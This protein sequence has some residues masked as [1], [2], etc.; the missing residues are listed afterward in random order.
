MEL[1]RNSNIIDRK[2]KEFFIPSILTAMSTSMILIVDGLIVSNMLGTKE[3]AAVNCCLPF[4]Q[5]L[6]MISDLLGLGGSV[7]I[8]IARG[9]RENRKADQLF[10]T[11]LL[12]YLVSCGLLW[13]PQ[14]LAPAFFSRI[15]TN[16]PVL[17]PYVLDYYSVL[18]WCAPFAIFFQAMAYIIRAEGRP[19][20]ASFITITANVINVVLDVVFMGIFRMGIRGAALASV[21]GWGVGGIISLCS[22]LFGTRPLKICFGR[23]GSCAWEIIKTGFPGAAGV[24]LVG[25]KTL[26]LNKIVTA[27]AGSEGM[28]AFSVC[29]SAL[30]LVSMFITGASETMMPILGIYYGENDSLGV[31]M[32]LR[33]A[34]RILVVSSGALLLV[35]EAAPGLLLI[36]YGVTD[37]AEV[38]VAT[39]ALRIYALSLVG[40]AISY[41]M[42]YYYL[43][44]E[45]QKLANLIML[46][47][48]FLVIVPCA[49]VLSKLMGI[50]G[51]WWSFG[52]TEL[53]TIAFI[54]V[55]AR[56]K[57]SNIYQMEEDPAMLE[58]SFLGSE[59]PGAEASMKVMQFLE[60]QGMEHKLVNKI[61]IA[62]EE[63]AEN[64]ARHSQ[65]KGN[66]IDLRLKAAS[67]GVMI[68]FCDDGPEFDPTVYQPE[69]KD[70]YAIDN[71]MML[72]AISPKMEYQRVIGLNKTTIF[73]S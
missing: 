11:L 27:T 8:S 10:T 71:I 18:V 57:V 52:I 68:S 9:R 34:F 72:R 56:G 38:A 70:C 58:V 64:I 36:P 49:Y 45:K 12:L 60:N 39:S 50:N 65:G 22:V 3:F 43:T 48:G 17:Y 73:L 63:M 29:I 14:V 33:K 28:V 5:L 55:M 2:F 44:I 15:L 46:I 66:H 37:P 61:G 51:V 24:G 32:V 4:L 20:L 47:N 13:L 62:V 59:T 1:I 42:L 23:L 40:C 69:E 21:V 19:R 41:L 35:L 6:A 30:S 16:D 54:F 7:A 53:V 25:V 26:C 31:R 67:Q